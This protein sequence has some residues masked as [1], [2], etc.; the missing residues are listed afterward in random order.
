MYWIVFNI[1]TG[2]LGTKRLVTKAEEKEFSCNYIVVKLNPVTLEK[3]KEKVDLT[4]DWR[5]LR[6]TDD[7]VKFIKLFDT[8]DNAA[9]EYE[10]SGRDEDA[11]VED[12]YIENKHAVFQ[13]ILKIFSGR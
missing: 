5:T 2:E 3:T 1:Q 9:W 6:N 11:T 8:I 4:N 7:R 13:Q 12:S 10:I